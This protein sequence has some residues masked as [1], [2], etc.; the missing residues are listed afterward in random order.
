MVHFWKFVFRRCWH[1]T[2]QWENAFPQMPQTRVTV[3]FVA[4]GAVTLMTLKHED[5]PEI[6]ICLQHRSGWLK[7]FDRIDKIL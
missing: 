1:N 4:E 6:P 5:L 3:E 7:A 2:W